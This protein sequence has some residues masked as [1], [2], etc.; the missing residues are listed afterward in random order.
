MF[1][2]RRLHREPSYTPPPPPPFSAAENARVI[3]CQSQARTESAGLVAAIT[4]AEAAV[5]EGNT[6]QAK[7]EAAGLLALAKNVTSAHKRLSSAMYDRCSGQFD[8]I[9]ENVQITAFEQVELLCQDIANFT[10]RGLAK[11]HVEAALV[12]ARESLHSLESASKDLP[13]GYRDSG[14]CM[15]RFTSACEAR[16]RQQRV[17]LCRTQWQFEMRKMRTRL[18]AVVASLSGTDEA[19]LPQIE[20]LNER[21][22][23]VQ[24]YYDRYGT[25]HF[26]T[27]GELLHEGSMWNFEEQALKRA[28]ALLKDIV[29]A[30][31]A[32]IQREVL[33]TSLTAAKA[34]LRAA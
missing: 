21:M 22:D 11:E 24:F 17:E 28:K 33:V 19:A 8:G 32:K 9:Q 26:N 6:E 25:A 10:R 27:T 16:L 31:K 5:R 20:A 15:P 18:D 12:L 23:V 30:A 13:E 2:R 14:V 1:N 3:L 4:R 29:S 7:S 34:E